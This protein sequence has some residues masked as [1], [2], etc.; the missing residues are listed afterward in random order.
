VAW[1]LSFVSEFAEG[2]DAAKAARIYLA[3]AQRGSK[4]KALRLAEQAVAA[5]EAA[6]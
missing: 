1:G 2:A 6:A 5:P 3:E 4:L